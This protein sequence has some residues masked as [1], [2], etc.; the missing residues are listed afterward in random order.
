MAWACWAAPLFVT[1]VILQ[2]KK[3]RKGNVALANKQKV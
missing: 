3:I 1:E 2:A